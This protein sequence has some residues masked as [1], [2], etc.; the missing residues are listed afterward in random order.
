[1]F[2]KKIYEFS[3]YLNLLF[4][5]PKTKEYTYFFKWNLYII[6]FYFYIVR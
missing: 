3:I 1:M 6:A 2:F 4:E 5:T